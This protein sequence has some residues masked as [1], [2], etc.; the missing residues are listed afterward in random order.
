MDVAY[1]NGNILDRD[2]KSIFYCKNFLQVRWVS[3]LCNAYGTF[4]LPNIIKGFRSIWQ[5][6][7][8]F[9][10]IIQEQPCDSIWT[11]WQ[12]FLRKHICDNKW[13]LRMTLGPWKTL[14]DSLDCLLSFYYSHKKN[15]LY[16]SYC[17]Q[18]WNH[19]KYQYYAHQGDDSKTFSFQKFTTCLSLITN[20][21]NWTHHLKQKYH[22]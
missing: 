19:R 11:I 3:D 7:S 1:S 12:R 4:I 8:K 9:E 17:F 21:Y 15:I 16:H 2:I 10:E 20:H 14:Y 22:F 5:F 18:W 13:N 6:K